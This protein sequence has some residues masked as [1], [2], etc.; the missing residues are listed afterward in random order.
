MTYDD[1]TEID[2][3]YVNYEKR[4]FLINYSLSRKKRWGTDDF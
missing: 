2:E 1:K 4:R 3:L